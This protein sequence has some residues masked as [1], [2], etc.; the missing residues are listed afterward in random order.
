MEKR[1]GIKFLLFGI[2]LLFIIIGGYILMLKSMPKSNKPEKNTEAKLKD[3]R[4]DKK[5]D[6]I[7]F[8]DSDVVNDHLAIEYKD[9]VLNFKNDTNIE[10][11]QNNETAEMKKTVKKEDNEENEYE[12]LV[13]AKYKLFEI[14][15]YEKYLSLV[16]NYFS[17]DNE[18]LGTYEKTVTYVFNKENGKLYSEDELL[19]EFN[20]TSDDVLKKV[21][22]YVDGQEKLKEEEKI[23]S[24]DTLKNI[25]KLNLFVDRIGRLSI[26]ILVKSDQKDY[27]DVIVLN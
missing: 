8:K 3:N 15:E 23:S 16:V 6:Y 5:K 13:S 20:F 19:K 25:D 7:Y 9:I 24:E 14:Y 2:F 27:N 11:E 17:F 22:E 4:I 26:S 10:K 21:K 18:N 1:N 12:G